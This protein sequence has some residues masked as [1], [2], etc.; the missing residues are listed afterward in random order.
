MKKEPKRKTTYINVG[1]AMKD[2]FCGLEIIDQDTARLRRKGIRGKMTSKLFPHH[3][4]SELLKVI[5]NF[6]NNRWQIEDL[7]EFEYIDMDKRN[8]MEIARNLIDLDIAKYIDVHRNILMLTEKGRKLKENINNENRKEIFR[9]IIIEHDGIRYIIKRIFDLKGNIS[10]IDIGNLICEYNKKE[11]KPNV[12]ISRGS[13][14]ISWFKE[15]GILEDS[16]TQFRYKISNSF[17]LNDIEIK[18]KID[19][20]KIDH[21]QF[22]DL[23]CEILESLN[24]FENVTKMGGAPGDLKRDI[25]ATEKIETA[26]GPEYR[27]WLIQCKHYQKSKVT[28]DDL[29]SLINAIPTH[30]SNGILIITSGELTPNARLYLEKF[31]DSLDNPY[32]A[33]WMEKNR[34]EE[35]LNDN[36]ELMNKYFK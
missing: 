13:A 27:K 29:P 18:N 1:R 34:L 26:F 2:I 19:W 30:N 22:E 17:S 4:A 14:L 20:T 31:N 36:K 10:S 23:C 25:S 8:N 28:P 6:H 15:A 11:W 5:D 33:K 35:L 3:T 9:G 12:K 16:E 7:S 24:Q 21:N 32:K